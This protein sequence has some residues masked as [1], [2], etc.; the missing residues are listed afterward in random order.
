MGSPKQLLRLRGRSLVAWAVD[1]ALASRA[2]R[3]FAVVGAHE[4][5]ISA[6]L[7]DREVET[8]ANSEWSSGLAS[9][10]RCGVRALRARGAPGFDAALLLLV[11][12][13]AVD[14]R[15]LD[16]LI[17]AFD[18][19][20]TGV[21]ACEYAGGPGVP[22]LFG[23]AHFDALCELRGDRGAKSLLVGRGRELR[24]IAFEPAAIDIDTPADY[25]AARARSGERAGD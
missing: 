21:V 13:P 23:S 17:D 2:E 14:A 22:A 20:E 16:R 25:E 3:V 11:D 10:I 7:A 12:Q 1:A 24:R 9:S 18:G 4:A 19:S 15:L 6:E 5:E 8:V